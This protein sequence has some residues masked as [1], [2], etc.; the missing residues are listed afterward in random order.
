MGK[1][2]RRRRQ[3][4]REGR[5]RRRGCE[6]IR[7][8]FVWLVWQRAH[9]SPGHSEG[10]I[11]GGEVTRDRIRKSSSTKGK[12]L[13]VGKKQNKAGV[14]EKTAAGDVDKTS[15]VTSPPR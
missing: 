14:W 15:L 8:Q 7:H 12:K 10:K 3:K 4:E 1:R 9:I 6:E 2:E 13:K 11:K 5:R